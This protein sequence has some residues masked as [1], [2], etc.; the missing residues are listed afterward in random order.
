[1]Q[2]ELDRS[3]VRRE[4]DQAG[5]VRARR[6]FAEP[7]LVALDEQLTPNTPQPPR[8]S[9]IARDLLRER[10]RASA[11]IGCGWPFA[12]VAVLLQVADRLRSW[13]R[14]HGAW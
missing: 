13:C 6:D 9:Q 2:R 12:V 7:H 4:R 5:V 11:D 14:R 1:M 10:C 8:S 3:C